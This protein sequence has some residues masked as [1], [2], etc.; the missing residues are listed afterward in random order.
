[1]NQRYSYTVV[2]KKSSA[3]TPSRSA[4][5]GTSPNTIRNCKYPNTSG[6]E[7]ILILADPEL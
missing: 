6:I 5:S 1:M 7:S 3:T 4:R 2:R